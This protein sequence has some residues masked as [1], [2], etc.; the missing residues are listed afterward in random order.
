[1]Q[2]Y[3]LDKALSPVHKF[4]HFEHSGGIILLIAVIVALILINSPFQHAYGKF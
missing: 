3:L 4:I 2:K 1:M